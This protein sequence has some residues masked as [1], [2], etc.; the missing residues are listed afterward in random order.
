LFFSSSFGLCLSASNPPPELA[1]AAVIHA[2]AERRGVVDIEGSIAERAAELTRTMS[3]SEMLRKWLTPVDFPATESKGHAVSTMCIGK[4]RLDKG[5]GSVR[6]WRLLRDAEPHRELGGMLGQ[7][8]R[9]GKGLTNLHTT[10]CKP[11]DHAQGTRAYG[12]HK[13]NKQRKARST[14][15]HSQQRQVSVITTTTVTSTMVVFSGAHVSVCY[16][17]RGAYDG[18]V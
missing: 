13:I 5:R 3:F 8:R 6:S 12:L 1:P 10:R 15:Q 2:D 11:T 9:P 18:M 7:G 17:G 14:T 16:N 4:L